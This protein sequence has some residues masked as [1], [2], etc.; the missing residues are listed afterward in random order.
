MTAVREAIVLP[1]LFL[2]VVLVSAIRPGTDVTIAPP[3][4]GALVAGM[5]LL[6][7]LIRSGCLAPACHVNGHKS[8]LANVNGVI[9]VLAL[10]AASAQVIAAVLPESGVPAVIGWMVLLSLLVQAFAMAPDRTRL[11][12]GLLVT[13]AAAYSLKYIVLAALSTPAQGRVA[14]ALQTLFEGLTFGVVSQRVLHPAE[15]YL[16]FLA[17]VLYLAGLALLPSAG[18]H[19]VR[20]PV[21]RTQTL[22]R[23]SRMLQSSDESS[24]NEERRS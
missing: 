17:I 19:I 10:F 3:S 6:A 24:V 2:T 16:A 21:D 20:V 4:P 12:R 8:A 15:P 7:L 13:F 22:D 18:W 5:A 1:I 23:Q 9:V 11:L 14:R